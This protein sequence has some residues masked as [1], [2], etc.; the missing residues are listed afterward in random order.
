[1]KKYINKIED[2]E[3][4]INYEKLLTIM[5]FKVELKVL[6]YVSNDIKIIKF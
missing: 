6:V 4:L 1:M 5:G 3:Q 2:K